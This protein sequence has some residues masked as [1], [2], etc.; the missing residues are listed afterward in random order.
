[1]IQISD[2]T[3]FEYEHAGHVHFKC[4][5]VLEIFSMLVMIS[6]PPLSGGQIRSWIRY[7]SDMSGTGLVRQDEFGENLHM[8]HFLALGQLP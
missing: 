3:Q 1:M 8:M 7:A 5:S 2:L 4:F 6:S